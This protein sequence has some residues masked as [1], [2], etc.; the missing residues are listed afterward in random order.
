MGSLAQK[1]GLLTG[2]VLAGAGALAWAVVKRPLPSYRERLELPELDGE[3]EVLWDEWGVPHVYAATED[4]L[5]L[6]QGYLHTQD[7]LWQMEFQ[8]RI[9]SGRLSE[10]FGQRTLETD[11]LLRRI[12]FR[13]VA[14]AEASALDQGSARMLV[15]YCAGVN[16]FLRAN[17]RRLP[18]EF[19]L[20]RYQPEAWSPVDTLAWGKL[21]AWGLSL[22]W[23]QEIARERLA[24]VIE[25]AVLAFLEHPYPATHPTTVGPAAAGD[26]RPTLAPLGGGASNAW[27]VAGAKTTS[28]KPLL[29]NDPHLTPQIPSAW[30]EVHLTCPAFEVAGVS[31][32]GAPGVFIGHNGRIAWGITASMADTQD[33]YV[34][35]FGADRATCR[36][37][38]GWEPTTVVLES[39]GIKGNPAPAVER[40]VLS[41]HGPILAWHEDGAHGYAV[42]SPTL[43]SNGIASVRSLVLAADWPQFRTAL[44]EWSWGALNFVYA[45]VD[46]NIGF[47][48]AGKL[49]RRPAHNGSLPVPGWDAA[50]DWDGY[51]GIDELSHT[52][53]PSN[54][55]VANANN[56]PSGDAATDAPQ[57]DWAD[58]YRAQRLHDV[59][60]A[61]TQLTAGQMSDLHM[62]ALSLAAREL[63]ALLATIEVVTTEARAARDLLLAWDGRVAA[64]SGAAALYQAFRRHLLRALLSPLLEANLE[65][66]FGQRI[67][68]FGPTPVNPFRA[69]SFLLRLL[70]DAMAGRTAGGRRLP[71]ASI[72]V[73]EALEQ[74]RLEIARSQGPDPAQWRWG[75]M[76]RLRLQHPLAKL[77]PLEWLFNRG[78]F[79]LRGDTDTVHQ[80]SFSHQQPYDATRWTPTYRFVADLANWDNCR[81]VHMPGQS[82][83]PGSRHYD[84]QLGLWLAGATHA[85]PFSRT[86]VH[87]AA[88]NRQR[89]L[90]AGGQA[91]AG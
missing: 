84:D 53:N 18:V 65:V 87:A 10:L 88:V 15:A 27:A 79:L 49:P 89:F 7:R 13:R 83:Q 4:D 50:F 56:R 55:F 74:A 52:L 90:P 68:A 51:L 72:A 21:M 16:A 24:S 8:R 64:A 75:A 70:R 6:V 86:A 43:R 22:N 31:L 46:G 40:V 69:S 2:A 19:T 25:P 30:Y 60:S 62:D 20:L 82:G 59:L 71:E 67:H 63:L 48:T 33:C 44:A 29:A 73:T 85:M 61:A 47:Q 76:H 81:S 34:E 14:E 66:Y 32:P 78:P 45:D 28:G 26:P 37:G 35:E 36:V 12:G 1:A 91:P 41:R 58:G 57:G 9:A 42:A 11:R 3:V 39:I 54:G 17:R 80:A 38:E 23:D 77:K 5:W